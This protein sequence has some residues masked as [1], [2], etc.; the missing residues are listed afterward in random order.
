M[1]VQENLNYLI[2]PDLKYLRACKLSWD[3]I[4][5]PLMDKIFANRDNSTKILN[6][7]FK[8]YFHDASKVRGITQDR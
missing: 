6:I 8:F 2:Y 5:Y 3:W 7:A 4:F 1:E